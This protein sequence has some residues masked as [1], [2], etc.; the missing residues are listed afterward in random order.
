MGGTGT[1]SSYLQLAS[2]TDGG[3]PKSRAYNLH[4]QQRG[5]AIATAGVLM[6]GVIFPPSQGKSH[7]I[8]TSWG[9]LSDVGVQEP[10][11]MDIFRGGHVVWS[12]L[13]GASRMESVKNW[14]PRVSSYP[15]WEGARKM[16]LDSTF[17]L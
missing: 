13:C 8:G 14:L 2:A 11:S 17:V 3:T 6:C 5:L 16:V 12:R 7:W 1:P 9:C 15:G 4:S 10:L